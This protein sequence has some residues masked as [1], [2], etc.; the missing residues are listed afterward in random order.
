MMQTLGMAFWKTSLIEAA[1]ELAQTSLGYEPI[2]VKEAT[3]PLPRDLPGSYVA[4]VGGEYSYEFGFAARWEHCEG[5][6]KR[7]LFMEA[8][9]EVSQDF[10]ADAMNELANMIGG[11]VKRRMV[12]FDSTLKL[13]LPVFFNGTVHPTAL[14]ERTCS[15]VSFGDYPVHL[16]ALRHKSPV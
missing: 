12:E 15:V 4:L 5:L 16:I 14:Q 7:M 11:G 13:G 9:E 1:D 10:I 3:F 8:D 2:G 6:V